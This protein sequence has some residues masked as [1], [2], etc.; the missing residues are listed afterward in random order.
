MCS[1]FG[2]T[3]RC[4]ILSNCYSFGRMLLMTHGEKRLYQEILTWVITHAEFERPLDLITT[5]YLWPVFFS[6]QA[7]NIISKTVN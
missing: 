3:P 1:R 7:F 4:L 2:M 6:F 5:L